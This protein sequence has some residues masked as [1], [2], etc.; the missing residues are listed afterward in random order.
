MTELFGF[1][2]EGKITGIVLMSIGDAKTQPMSANGP[3]AKCWNVRYC[4]GLGV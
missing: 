4:A 3:N 2:A 1:N